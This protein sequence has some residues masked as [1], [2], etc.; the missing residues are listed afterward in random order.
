LADGS[1]AAISLT[2][3]TLVAATERKEVDSRQFKVESKIGGRATRKC[4]HE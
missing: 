1:T 2:W 3:S 4:R